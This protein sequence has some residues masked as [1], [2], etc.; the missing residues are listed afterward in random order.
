MPN[1]TEEQLTKF[2]LSP[3]QATVYLACLKLG[4]VKVGLIQK[5]A[6]LKRTTLYDVL[7]ELINLGLISYT[8][9]QKT[10]IFTPENPSALENLL[11]QK[12]QAV[13][14]VLADLKSLFANVSC[15]PQI[16]FYEGNEGIKQIYLESL[17]ARDKKIYQIVSV[18][19]FLEFPGKDFMNWYVQERAK[20]NIESI[21]I[22]PKSGDVYSDNFGKTDPQLKRQV[23]YL[24]PSLFSMSM[25]MIFDHYVAALSTKTENYGFIIE[26]KEYSKS[27]KIIFDFL[28]R[29][30]SSEYESG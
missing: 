15:R 25:I 7:K 3:K 19:D 18:K 13:S 30:G 28:W 20:K 23:H 12:Q 8:V 14:A 17:Q 4:P 5:E 11:K 29:L 21:A 16:R 22:H 27:M 6:G 2:G 9:K 1:T 26:S 24:P 10:K